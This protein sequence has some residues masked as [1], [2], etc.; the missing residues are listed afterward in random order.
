MSMMSGPRCDTELESCLAGGETGP[1][2]TAGT[3]LSDE[4]IDRAAATA[5]GF[6]ELERRGRQALDELLALPSHRDRIARV[7]RIAGDDET[8]RNPALV[9]LLLVRSRARLDESP[10]EAEQAAELAAEVARCLLDGAR[11][12]E[13]YRDLLAE[14]RA[15]QAD[16]LRSGG[17][18]RAAEVPLREA[19]DRAARSCDLFLYAEVASVAA[20]L[21]KDQRRWSVAH[22]ELDRAERAY[23]EIDAGVEY[24]DA[25]RLSRA[26]VA[27]LSGVSAHVERGARDVIVCTDLDSTPAPRGP[28]RHPAHRAGPAAEPVS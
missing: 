18:L 6:D 2:S 9:E 13:L 23:L 19:Q 11:R 4:L 8:F 12:R 15:H 22:E 28:R 17:E 24:L 26:Q 7:A 16:A 5:L 20:A 3:F 27:F 25:V 21:A 10:A 1:A 14:A